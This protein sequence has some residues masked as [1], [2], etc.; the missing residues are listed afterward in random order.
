MSAEHKFSW[1]SGDLE[2]DW[3]GR[4]PHD[5]Q[6]TLLE[7]L[8]HAPRSK[9][10][11]ANTMLSA[12]PEPKDADDAAARAATVIAYLTGGYRVGDRHPTTELR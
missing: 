3:L 10:E 8:R 6:A 7:L 9:G 2:P 4:A 11:H 5:Q 12:P 1:Q